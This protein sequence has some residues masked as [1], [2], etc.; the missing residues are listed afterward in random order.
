MFKRL[1]DAGLRLKLAKCRFASS[2]VVYL[3]FVVAR[4][5]ISPDPQKVAAVRDFPRPR[6]VRTLCSFLGL[7]SYYRRFM[8][9][10][11]VVANPLFALTKKDMEFIWSAACEE[12]FQKLKGLL[13]E[14]PVLAFPEFDRGFL[15]DT[16][17]SGVGLGVVLAQKQNDGS[18]RPVAYASRTLPPHE[19]NYGVT[20][21]EALGVV[22]AV[23]HLRH[24]PYGHHCD[25]FTD[26]EALESLL[27]TP[28]PSGKHARWGL[29]LQEV[30]LSIL[31]RP[32]KKNV[33]A[34]ALSRSPLCEKE[35]P[36]L[37]RK[38]TLVAAVESTQDPAKSRGCNL[39]ERQRGDPWLQ[40]VIA[41][42]ETGALPADESKARE[43]AVS[44]Q[45]Y[46]LLEGVLYH[47]ERDKTLRVI[48]PEC[49]RRPLFDEVHGGAFSG[50]LRDAKIHGELSKR[51]WWLKMRSDII[52]W[53]RA[54]LVCASRQ[55]GQAVHPPL[56]PIPVTG[57]F[58]RVGVDVLHFSK[59]ASGT[60]MR[61]CSST[62]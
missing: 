27:N 47:V 21:L 26:H 31:Y 19:Q 62:I 53:C 60:S 22:W 33:L 28:H 5:G 11:S 57:P 7:A 42:L 20:E 6:D 34:D 8:A 46:V 41:Y 51:Y 59:S 37:V 3:G 58:D 61:W 49:D 50:H 40:E 43:L 16:D 55:V 4:E 32:G 23:Q 15:L 44:G 25:V 52:Q 18:V 29:A 36:V 10:F 2:K 56:T 12:A 17:A 9:G 1:H 39:G 48:P 14:A 13:I 38:E 30:D 35:S 45:L 24:Y 54:C